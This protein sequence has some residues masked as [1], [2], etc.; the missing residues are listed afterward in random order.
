MKRLL[1]VFGL[2]GLVWSSA[3]APLPAADTTVDRLSAPDTTRA[4]A[5]E[6]QAK[7]RYKRQGDNCIWDTNDTGPNQCTPRTAGR[8]KKDGNRCYWDGND[9][10]ADQC[11]P[12]K[13]RFKVEGDRCVWA[14]DDDGANQCNPK[15]PR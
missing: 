3:E 7:G 14:P 9:R 13:G 1:L 10:G 5:V 6:P 12:P 2:A 8:F 11:T 15:Q 4:I